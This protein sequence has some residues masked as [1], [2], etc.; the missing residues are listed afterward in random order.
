[1]SAGL[2]RFGTDFGQ[3]ERDR[4]FFQLDRER[5]HY[6]AA[7]RAAPAERRMLLSGDAEAA[8]ARAAALTW[9]RATLAE[10][11]PVVLSEA[12]R[13][14]AAL[15]ELDALARALQE[16][17][18][19]MCAGE[20]YA[21]RAA[22][23]DVRFPS[24]WRP[25]RLAGADFRSLHAPVPGFPGDDRAAQSMVRSM[26]ERGPF[27]RFVWTLSP[28]DRLDHHPDAPHRSSWE[29]TDRAWL[30]VERQITVPLPAANAGL[31]LIR[32]YH[33][34]LDQLSL[35]ERERAITALAVMPEELRR[36]KNLPTLA[37]LHA[38]LQRSARNPLH[39]RQ[40]P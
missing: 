22:L 28:D 4:Q 21:G 18:C 36:Y 14:S 19:V 29:H 9:M 34:A 32:V 26:I 1:M 15:D 20:D 31:F 11:A 39:A 10:Q 25:E 35:D 7:K 37:G 3:G 8:L 30:R 24:G 16:D 5:A 12:A 27:V 13:D 23:I 2:K 17:F 6:L 40:H 33:Y 38:V